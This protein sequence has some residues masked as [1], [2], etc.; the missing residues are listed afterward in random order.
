MKQRIY[1]LVCDCGD[2]SAT[3]EFFTDKDKCEE[4]IEADPESYGLNEDVSYFDVDGDHNIP[5]SHCG[6]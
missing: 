4:L 2:G 5:I 1:Y 6:C 3:V